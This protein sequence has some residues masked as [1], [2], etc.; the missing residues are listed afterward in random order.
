MSTKRV[1]IM[2]IAWIQQNEVTSILNNM[3]G[4]NILT[5]YITVELKP[6]QEL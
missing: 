6:K 1:K 2:F 4:D 3:L 5:P